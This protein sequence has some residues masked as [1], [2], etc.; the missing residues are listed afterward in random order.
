MRF[1]HTFK[2]RLWWCLLF[3]LLLLPRK[4]LSRHSIAF[5]LE[6]SC[7]LLN[8]R[9]L[10]SSPP[11]A[12]AGAGHPEDDREDDNEGGHGGAIRGY[13]T[14]S[15]AIR[16][17]PTP[18]GRPRTHARRHASDSEAPGSGR[19]LRGCSED[20]CARP[21]GASNPKRNL[22]LS[23]SEGHKFPLRIGCN[24]FWTLQRKQSGQEGLPMR[25]E[26]PDSVPETLRTENRA[27]V[28]F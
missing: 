16:G 15:Y 27:L 10:Y 18:C 23:D 9:Y 21:L 28:N 7:D 4:L 13:T 24:V 19:V 5:R 3:P 25:P 20:A 26:G 8:Q 2:Q 17:C 11:C 14:L 22:G 6:E 12:P 1:Y